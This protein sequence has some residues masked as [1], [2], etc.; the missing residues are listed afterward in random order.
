[1]SKPKN[2]RKERKK[3]WSENNAVNLHSLN[4]KI[5]NRAGDECSFRDVRNKIGKG[6]TVNNAELLHIME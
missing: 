4:V 1:M 5:I 2:R 3:I 6:E